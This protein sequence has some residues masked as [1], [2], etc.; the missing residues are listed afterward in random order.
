MDIS[1]VVPLLN[2]KE[3]LGEL[4]DWIARVM[5]ENKFSYEIILVDDGSTDGSWQE[6]ERLAVLN[7]NIHG[8]GLSF[9]FVLPLI[10]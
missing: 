6:I 8:V 5:E 2:E 4:T 10:Y 7:G 1:I 3:S 9:K